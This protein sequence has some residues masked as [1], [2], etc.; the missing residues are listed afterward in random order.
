[1]L[2]LNLFHEMKFVLL[3]E[4]SPVIGTSAMMDFALFWKAI[5]WFNFKEKNI[6]SQW[7]MGSALLLKK[8]SKNE[9]NSVRKDTIWFER[10]VKKKFSG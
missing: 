9:K 3:L 1:M 7:N 6:Y 8:N 2:A 4:T 5:K 10:H